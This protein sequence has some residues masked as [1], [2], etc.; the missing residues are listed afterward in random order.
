MLLLHPSQSGYTPHPFPR[1]TQTLPP[2]LLY[3]TVVATTV[4]DSLKNSEG[5]NQ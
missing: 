1:P 3:N 2:T 5:K 4:A